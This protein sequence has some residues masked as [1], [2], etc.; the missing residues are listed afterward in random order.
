M[1]IWI[2]DAKRGVTLVYKSFLDLPVKDDLVSGLLTALNQ[3]LPMY[4]FEAKE[5]DWQSY[6]W[7]TSSV[8]NHLG[9]FMTQQVNPVGILRWFKRR[10]KETVIAEL[11]ITSGMEHKKPYGVKIDLYDPIFLHVCEKTLQ[12]LESRLNSKHKFTF[13]YKPDGLERT[14]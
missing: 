7:N 2:L 1:N 3:G 10:T 6:M 9:I 8:T 12:E 11:K 14:L 4:R 13:H 5:T